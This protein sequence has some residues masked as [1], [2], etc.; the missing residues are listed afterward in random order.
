MAETFGGRIKKAWNAFFNKDLTFSNGSEGGGYYYRP[1]RTQLSRGTERSIIT[2]IYNRISMDVADIQIKHVQ[3]DEFDRFLDIVDSNLNNCLS[4]EANIDQTGRA[5][6]Q[7]AVMSMLDEGVVALV[8]IVTNRNPNHADGAF[9]IYSIRTGK[10]VAWYPDRVRVSVYNE[11][12]GRREEIM[13]HKSA[14]AI[15]ENPLYATMNEKNSVMQ[16]LTRKLALLDAVDEQSSSGKLDLI[17][18]LPYVVKSEARKAQ[19]EDRRKELENQLTS[20]KYGIAYTDGTEKIVQLNRSI[21]NNL[22]GQIEYLTTLLF[23]QLGLTQTIMDGSADGQTMLNY[24]NRTIE[25]IISAIT[26]EMIRK[27]LTKRARTM[28]QSIKFFRD[29]FKLV[30]VDQLADLAD[31]FTRNEIMT[32]NEVRQIIGLKPS[33]DPN[34]DVLLNKNI[35]HPDDGMGYPEEEMPMDEGASM[36]EQPMEENFDI[37]PESV[38]PEH[39]YTQTVESVVPD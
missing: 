8:P 9:D 34:A 32:S 27:F 19:A 36:E 38:V 30:P 39:E 17:I 23:S 24:Y 22:M 14:I 7:D 2:S 1:D 25:P 6:I 33:S 5:F 15:V 3:L 12:K 11:Q 18:Q 37:P 20:S 29:P 4:I 26:D 21:E 16:R 13:Y 31:R 28:K 10:I 35:A